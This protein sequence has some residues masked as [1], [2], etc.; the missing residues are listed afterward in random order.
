[1]NRREKTHD[2]A[3]APGLAAR[4]AAQSIL[5]DVLRKKRPLDAAIAEALSRTQLAPRDAGFARTIAAT[6]LRRFGQ[7]E[8]LI[9]AFVPKAPPPHK[10]GPT[11]E[12]LIAGA[13]ELLF[14]N[15]APH[16]AVDA[17][18]RLAQADSKAV[19]FKALINAVLRRIAREG[20]SVTAKQDEAVLNT[21]DWLW[22]RW[23]EHFGEST[24]RAIAAAHLEVPP[25]DLT[26]KSPEASYAEFDEAALLAP[27]RL[28]LKH[29]GR[30]EELPGYQDGRWWVQDFAASL[31]TR[32]FGDVAGKRVIDLCAAPGGKTAQ[33]AANGARVTAVDLVPER[34]ELVRENLNRLRLSAELVAA[35]ARDWRPAEPA[36]FVLLDAPCMATGTIRRH[37]DLP[38]LK[39]AADLQITESLQSE[40]LDAAAEMTATGGTLVYAVCSLEPE[41]GEQQVAAF[42][43]RNGNFA[44]VPVTADEI[45]DAAFVSAEGDLK[46]LPCSWAGKGGMDGFYAA[47]LKNHSSRPSA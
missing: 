11:L 32:L 42:L 22:P 31:P 14:L 6:S 16:A 36:P 1:M 5:S 30:V 9:R 45:F 34:L 19:H 18:N 24:A 15:V 43:R 40:L 33:L 17:A 37:P 21:P 44:R 46:T 7:L 2:T 27:G 47:R 25:L 26:L 3:G 8:A 39:S 41:E 20:T 35:D 38:W 10:A 4:K 29:A 28:R 12:I 23:T 13:A